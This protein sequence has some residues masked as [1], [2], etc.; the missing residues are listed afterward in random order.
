MDGDL[1]ELD[2]FYFISWLLDY[3][4]GHPVSEF[5]ARVGIIEIMKEVRKKY[6]EPDY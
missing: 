4:E 2:V 1:M 3:V 5:L 6:L